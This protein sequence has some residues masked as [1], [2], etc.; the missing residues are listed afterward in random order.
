[1][2][3]YAL[4]HG[5]SAAAI[6]ASL[7]DDTGPVGAKRYWRVLVLNTQEGGE[8]MPGTNYVGL[9]YI[10]M[11]EFPDGVDEINPALYNIN[12]SSSPSFGSENGYN[13]FRG[14]A[15][16]S[17]A[18]ARG[19][20]DALHWYRWDF[21]SGQDKAI[22]ELLVKPRISFQ[23]QYPTRFVLQ[24]SDDGSTWTN[25][26]TEDH[27]GE[28]TFVWYEQRPFKFQGTPKPTDPGRETPH[29]YW[30][31]RVKTYFDGSY[32]CIN[33]AKFYT[34]T[35][36]GEP[37]STSGA[38]FLAASW[39]EGSPTAGFTTG[40]CITSH[41]SYPWVMEIKYPTAQFVKAFSM[42][43]RNGFGQAPRDMAIDYSDDGQH[44]YQAW[45]I[46]TQPAWALDEQRF[47][48]DPGQL[49]ETFSLPWDLPQTAVGAWGLRRLITGYNGP[50]VRI[51]D[52]AT[53]S[54]QDVGMDA[55]GYLAPF[56]VTG[57]A[58]V[59]R[60]YD[61]TGGDDLIQ[62]T[63]ANQPILYPNATPN[64]RAAI[65]ADGVTD[66]LEG[67][68]P[69]TDRPYMITYPLAVWM[70]G[71]GY[72]LPSHE[73]YANIWG[74]PHAE[75][76][77]ASPYKRVGLN[78]LTGS[79]SET[80]ALEVRSGTATEEISTRMITSKANWG[81]LT[82]GIAAGRVVQG[83]FPGLS[84]TVPSNAVTYPNETRLKLFTNGANTEH[85]GGYFSELTIFNAP[86]LTEATMIGDMTQKIDIAS[87]C[88]LFGTNRLVG[89]VGS[90]TFG[91]LSKGAA[92]VEFFDN[93]GVNVAE[94]PLQTAALTDFN[95]SE[96]SPRAFD[97]NPDTWWASSNTAGWTPLLAL[98]QERADI[99]G[100]K[101]QARPDAFFENTTS[102]FYYVNLDREGWHSTPGALSGDHIDLTPVGGAA[103]RAYGWN[104]A[105]DVWLEAPAGTNW[106][107]QVS[108]AIATVSNDWAGDTVRQCLL[109]SILTQQGDYIRLTFSAGPGGL[110]IDAATAGLSSANYDFDSTPVAVRF[111]GALG[112]SIGA[113]EK[114]ISDPIY[115]GPNVGKNLV[116]AFHVPAGS[117]AQSNLL[118]NSSQ[119]GWSRAYKA[120]VDDTA[121]LVASGYTTT[122]SSAVVSISKVEVGAETD[123]TPG[124][125]SETTI[126]IAA[127][128]VSS[129]LTAFPMRIDLATM[130]GPF[131]ANV[132]GEGRNI[133][134][135][136]LADVELPVDV[137]AINRTLQTGEIFVK[138]NL[139]AGS[140]NVFNVKTI[141]AGPA[142]DPTAPTGRHAVWAD[143]ECV[144]L[145]RNVADRTANARNL[146]LQGTG[147][148]FANGYLT[149]NGNG[150][151]KA[152]TVARLTTWTMGCSAEFASFGANKA[153]LSY[154][155]E[156]TPNTNRESLVYRSATPN[157][158][159]WNSTDTWLMDAGAAPVVN[160]RY[161]LHETFD[162]TVSRK[163]Y[164]NGALAAT[165]LGVSQRPLVSESDVALYVGV[166]N[167]TT[168]S[169]M[170]GKIGYV[171]LRSGELSAAWL[172]AEY[173]S[174]ETPAS[175]YTV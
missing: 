140:S 155:H 32:I 75:G 72:D 15:N 41:G 96:S 87:T 106:S 115:I 16:T 86:G 81:A 10:G 48:V 170:S 4:L 2:F 33:R 130:P 162:T 13:A 59:V 166:E 128:K 116:I 168:T 67:A 5:V 94:S 138:V 25:A 35:E 131:W 125:N 111:K 144:H 27:R 40:N 151:A 46:P 163:I 74:I 3:A 152:S 57:S 114:I 71:A 64:G 172:A 174:W 17:T 157:F 146:T 31:V 78:W 159:V 107:T 56:T 39:I 66:Y 102:K 169:R 22:Q 84:W 14:P 123:Q 12:G 129:D 65:K 100:G 124:G 133:R 18:T 160:T 156:S 132:G 82:Y 50:L 113:N 148:T 29:R 61:Q 149:L 92:E 118:T 164:R 76:S 83:G 88:A 90:G 34:D 89:I 52:T 122:G 6:T 135:Y 19:D 153:A 85:W 167:Q 9:S 77:N 158:G 70:G 117:G 69:G 142:I 51:R 98:L 95:D 171:Y 173:L 20:V 109:N 150:D 26:F 58:A 137:V 120:D 136:T 91:G 126:T 112:F 62:I 38:E 141:A 53:E 134:V 7:G 161:R 127:G 68:F 79:A 104:M 60:V 93:A 121:S 103:G 63:N 110:A 47:F 30:R 44:W 97:G 45:E 36:F 119:T 55:E 154:G 54:E 8:P 139:L 143:F 80:R 1:M 101:L 165:D 49:E 99:V 105:G 73:N 28:P 108:P 147:Q 24:A 175:F 23:N 11:A 43:S 42:Y 145:M 37:I 21:G